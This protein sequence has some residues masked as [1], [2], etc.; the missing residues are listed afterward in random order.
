MLSPSARL[1]TPTILSVEKDSRSGTQVNIDVTAN[2][3]DNSSVLFPPNIVSIIGFQ[4]QKTGPTALLG[5]VTLT[6]D[7]TPIYRFQTEPLP[8]ATYVFMARRNIDGVNYDSILSDPVTISNSPGSFPA[9]PPPAVP[10]TPS[11]PSSLIPT[12]VSVEKDSQSGTK[13][14]IKGTAEY[15]RNSSNLN[16]IAYQNQETGPV[17]TIGVPMKVVGVVT[18]PLNEPVWE[19]QTE[20]LPNATY[21]F[22]ARRIVDYIVY[23][24]NLSA[25][26]TISN[27]PG[28]TGS[29]GNPSIPSMIIPSVTPSVPKIPPLFYG[30]LTLEVITL[31]VLFFVPNSDFCKN[32]RIPCATFLGLWFCLL[33]ILNSILASQ[34]HSLNKMQK[35][36]IGS[37]IAITYLSCIMLLVVIYQLNPLYPNFSQWAQGNSMFQMMSGIRYRNLSRRTDQQGS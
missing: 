33:L 8:N 19:F 21:V 31:I 24:S 25:P 30:V 20:S 18:I 11:S 35:G 12:I 17:T 15:S 1:Y 13:V 23:S 34:I 2:Y 5:T 3:S 14:I 28:S 29:G 37:L 22:Q 4:Y 16:I 26:I 7:R 32:N 27:S 10:G 6:P 9:G 36:L